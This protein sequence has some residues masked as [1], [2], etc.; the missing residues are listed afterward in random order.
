MSSPAGK[1]KKHTG[2]ARR[3]VAAHTKDPPAVG[4]QRREG[5]ASIA[6]L[7]NLTAIPHHITIGTL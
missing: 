2:P 3:L 7:A 6:D 5:E 4:D 1:N